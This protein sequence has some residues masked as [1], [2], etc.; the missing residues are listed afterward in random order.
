MGL[1]GENVQRAT[2]VLHADLV[3]S[4]NIAYVM[5]APRDLTV[6]AAHVVSENAQNAGTAVLLALENWGTAGTAVEG[7]VAAAVGG[8]ATAARLS[9]RT[10]VAATITA[11]Q[12]YIDEGEWLVVDWTEEGAGWIS[13]DIFTYQVDFVYGKVG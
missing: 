9:A 1:G 12:A 7:T 6:L 11:A 2:L 13:G 4:G 5:K 8:T 10:P 3:G